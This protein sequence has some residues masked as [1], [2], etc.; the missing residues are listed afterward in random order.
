MARYTRSRL[1]AVPPRKVKL[2]P[3]GSKCDG[4]K[5]P[6]EIRRTH[7]VRRPRPQQGQRIPA[8]AAREAEPA[9]SMACWRSSSALLRRGNKQTGKTGEVSCRSSSRGW[10]TWCTGPALPKSATPPASSSGMATS[11]VNGRKVDIRPT[12]SPRTTSSRCAS[13]PRADPFVIARAEAGSGR[14]RAWL[15][16][17]TNQMRIP[18]ALVAGPQVIDTQSKSS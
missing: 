7:R 9:G 4:P 13:L 12:G 15:E 18:G 1:P 6:I 16:V 17:I 11:V 3:K 10:T 14:C 2:F 5:C 8:A